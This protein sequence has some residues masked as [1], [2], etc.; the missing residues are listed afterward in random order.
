MALQQR[1][2]IAQSNPQ[3]NILSSIHPYRLGWMYA[4]LDCAII[5]GNDSLSIFIAEQSISIQH[6]T[7]LQ[8]KYQ[9][10]DSSKDIDI[11]LRENR[12]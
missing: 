7:S 3:V 9:D 8:D 6:N 11:K 10:K 2:E 4:Y 5:A 12:H 1:P